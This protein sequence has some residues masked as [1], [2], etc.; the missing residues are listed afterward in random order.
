MKRAT[1]PGQYEITID[2]SDEVAGRLFNFDT[3]GTELKKDHLPPIAN[4]VFPILRAGG[5]ASLLG[6]A[7]ITGSAELDM[8]LSVGRAK[9]VEDR[10][11]T[12]WAW[13]PN[14]PFGPYN[15]PMRLKS[16]RGV[17]KEFAAAFRKKTDIP[18]DPK[19]RAVWF[20]AWQK[21]T[22]P[23]DKI[24]IDDIDLPDL[25][26]VGPDIGK[27]L[28]GISWF[29]G[30]LDFADLCPVLDLV[31]SVIDTL[32][33]LPGAW[34]AADRAAYKNG[35]IV[36][37]NNA[38]QDMADAYSDAALDRTPLGQWP[39]IPRPEPHKA[40]WASQ[41]SV[42]QQKSEEGEQAGCDEAYTEMQRLEASPKHKHVVIHGEPT[43]LLFTAKRWLRALKAK[44]DDNVGAAH[45]IIWRRELAKK[46]KKW[47]VTE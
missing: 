40:L 38:M 33:A 10:L 31:A 30:A 6:L 20:H 9:A 28:D 34:L 17:G 2:E 16:V 37:Y 41:P 44:F 11:R 47:P 35:Y 24:F 22:P 26:D 27:W 36:G 12:L 7:S 15:G 14:D 42:T 46:G 1:G 21:P 39:P 5:S 25:G 32:Y 18:N 4:R 13:V 45:M 43:V 8:T 3:E 29:I 23:P 19:W